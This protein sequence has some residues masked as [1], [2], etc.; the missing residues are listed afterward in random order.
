MSLMISKK[1]GGLIPRTLTLEK[2]KQKGPSNKRDEWMWKALGKQPN[3]QI[4]GYKG[5]ELLHGSV[6]RVRTSDDV[7][8]EDAEDEEDYPLKGLKRMSPFLY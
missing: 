4:R 3:K 1:A 7:G 8:A 5:I 6:R 2:A